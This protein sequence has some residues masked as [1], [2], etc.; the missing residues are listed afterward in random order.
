MKIVFYILIGL[1]ALFGIG[2]LNTASQLK[3]RHFG[4]ILG[5]LCYLG[6]AIGAY[7]LDSWWPF[8][9]GF[10]LAWVIRFLGGDPGK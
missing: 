6:G 5:G 9:I 8:L 4:L 1:F 7:T 10:G 2:T 3:F